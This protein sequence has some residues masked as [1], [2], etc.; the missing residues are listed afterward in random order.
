VYG[1]SGVTSRVPTVASSNAFEEILTWRPS[2]RVTLTPGDL[3]LRRGDAAAAGARALETRARRARPA[4]GTRGRPL[5]WGFGEVT[6]R[7]RRARRK[8]GTR[9]RQTFSMLIGVESL[10]ALKCTL[11]RGCLGV[12]LPFIIGYS[13]KSTPKKVLV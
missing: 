2:A 6:T 13:G 4:R 9:G 7:V 3:G 10:W 1:Q 8:W 11:V 12:L 5:T